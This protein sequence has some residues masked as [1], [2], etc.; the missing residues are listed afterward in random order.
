[1]TIGFRSAA[2]WPGTPRPRRFDQDLPEVKVNQ[3]H[4]SAFTFQDAR[5]QPERH[6]FPSSHQRYKTIQ[7]NS[8]L[9]EIP[10]GTALLEIIERIQDLS[11]EAA[12]LNARLRDMG[13]DVNRISESLRG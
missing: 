8:I 11:Q 13:V 3:V 7:G 2:S 12:S 6:K 1:M 9:V 10:N 5:D 4:E